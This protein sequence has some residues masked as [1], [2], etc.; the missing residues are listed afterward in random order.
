M[1][2]T[3]NTPS[4]LIVN[5]DTE[6]I[7]TCTSCVKEINNGFTIDTHDITGSAGSDVDMDAAGYRSNLWGD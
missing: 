2:K 5:V 6:A 4:M 3:Y 1:K 7:M